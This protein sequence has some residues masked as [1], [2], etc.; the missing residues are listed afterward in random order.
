MKKKLISAVLTLML[1]VSL[2]PQTAFADMGESGE[3][4]C[5][6]LMNLPYAEAYENDLNNSVEV[7]VFT[8][9]TKTKTQTY[10]L[11]GGS[12]H[13]S[14]DEISGVIFPVYVSLDDL[15]VLD[16][17]TEITDSSSVDITVTNRGQTTTTTLTGAKV[18][19][20]SE[21]YS[22]Y[23]LDSEPDFYK[24]LIMDGEEIHFG[25][26][27][28]CSEATV[29]SDAQYEFTTN[30]SYGDYQLN[31]YTADGEAFDA[32]GAEEIYEVIVSTEEGNDYGMRHMEN[33]WRTYEIAWCTGF[34][35]AV[36][37]CPTSSAHY[38]SMMGQTI[39]KVTYYTSNGVFVIDDLSIE[40]PETQYVWMNIPYDEF[41]NAEINVS[42]RNVTT[43]EN[44]VAVDAVSSATKAKTL[45]GNLVAGS[46]HNNEDGTD[47][48]GITYPV[49]VRGVNLDE[50]TEITDEDSLTITT[51]NRGQTSTAVYEGK[52]ALFGAGDY[53]YYVTDAEAFPSYYKS[54]TVTTDKEGVMT[55]AF[56]K[57]SSERTA[58]EAEASIKTDTTYGDYQISVSGISADTVYAVVLTTEEGHAYGLRHLEN[59][60][61]TTELA[62]SVGK[63][64][65]VHG[66]TLSYEHYETM[67]GETIT[68]ITYYT[69]DGIKTIACELY[70]PVLTDAEVTV[71]SAMVSDGKTTF[72]VSGLPEDFEPEYEV[73]DLK[74]DI[75]DGVIT[76]P[77]DSENGK[78]TLVISDANGKYDSIQADFSLQITAPAAYN[79]DLFA[80]EPQ[81]IPAKDSSDE[82]FSDYLNAVTSVTVNGKTYA[83]TGRQAVIV[84]DDEGIVDTDVFA[85]EETDT[86]EVIVSATG[87]TDYSFTIYT[88]A[89]EITGIELSETELTLASGESAVITA[90]LL[91]LGARGDLSWTSSDESVATV[92]D[93]KITVLKYSAK[94]VTVTVTAGDVSA[95]CTVNTLFS[96]VADSAKYYFTP[97]YWAAEEGIT[98]GMPGSVE[99]G[100]GSTCTRD[101]LIVFLYRLAGTPAVTTAQLNA[102]AKAFS[103]YGTLSSATFKKAI[104][105]AYAKGISK[106]YT[107]GSLAG[108]FGVNKTITRLEA[109][110]MLYRFAGK[111]AP[112]QSNTVKTFKDVE[113][114]YGKTTDSYRAI[115]WASA[116]G[117]TGGYKT[118]ASLPEGYTSL[119]TPCFGC[120]INCYR[121]DMVTFL[122]RYAKAAGML[123]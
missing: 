26:T 94:P 4:G 87:Y 31:L 62:W 95:V 106:G 43:T 80:E 121:Q 102:A 69:N 66:C 7:D 63:T 22:Y 53:A 47:I 38:E 104:A 23:V 112:K 110:I 10:N 12:W 115:A 42:G 2:L 65:D 52:D 123:K 20:A 55:A 58:L 73:E 5:Y 30:T 113:G 96:D 108:T 14:E 16:S 83:A 48:S 84:I 86:Y 122:Y 74:A 49:L 116:L 8:S 34:T 60:W 72:T 109:M 105:W 90:D 41:F 56:S 9:A 120:Q 57:D 117:I 85:D 37:N 79:G 114:V 100:V 67:P 91:P 6:V 118:Q 25:E 45:T 93:G 71:E 78:Y 64:L 28:V 50:F 81:L 18:L 92:S 61:R 77:T 68:G 119:A 36:H 70:V 13:A 97:V 1:I 32:D 54:Y 24:E 40:V 17:F 35:S 19:F 51:T 82:E 33:V 46:Y 15:D 59:V 107:T 29:I 88:E 99:F 111:P 103:D 101:Q 44:E 75:A 11:A 3:E 76:F 39:N 98:N 89:P 27:C 21:A